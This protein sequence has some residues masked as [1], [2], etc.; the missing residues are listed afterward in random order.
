MDAA[1]AKTRVRAEIER[2]TPTLIELSH[3]IH[4]RP[5]LNFEEHFAHDVLTGTLEDNGIDV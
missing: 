2:L 1:E 3:A 5:E 4:D